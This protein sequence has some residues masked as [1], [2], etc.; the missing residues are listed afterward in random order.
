MRLPGDV[1]NS[2]DRAHFL[3]D[4]YIKKFGLDIKKFPN[5]HENGL[6]HVYG[7]QEKSKGVFIALEIL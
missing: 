4:G 7:L 5:Y 1:N 6:T 3:T 2:E